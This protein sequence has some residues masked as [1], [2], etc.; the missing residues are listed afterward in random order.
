MKRRMVLWTVDYD[1]ICVVITFR[2]LLWLDE[3]LSVPQRKLEAVLIS[4]YVLSGISVL[5]P[6][7]HWFLYIIPVLYMMTGFFLILETRASKTDR[8]FKL[9]WPHRIV[10]RVASQAFFGILLVAAVLP[11]HSIIDLHWGLQ[12]VSYVFLAYSFC[13][14]ISGT[15]GRKRK[16]AIQKLKEAFTWLPQPVW[17]RV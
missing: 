16:A 7:K 4:V 11:P 8:M 14:D 3:W 1:W 2:I 15:N 10:G 17:D 5:L 9:I 13:L 6:Y 12:A